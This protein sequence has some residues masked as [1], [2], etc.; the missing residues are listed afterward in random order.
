[1]K[2]ALFAALSLAVV[3]TASSAA[4]D[5]ATG[6]LSVTATVNKACTVG[7]GTLAF[8]TVVPA[9]G[10]TSPVTGSVSVTC[11]VGTTFDVGLGDGTNYSNPNRRMRV[12]AT[13]NYLTYEIYRD[14]SAT[15]RFGNTDATDRLTAQ[16][17][18]GSSANT[19]NVYGLVPSGQAGTAGEGSYTDTVVV[20]VIY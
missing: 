7:G 2:R 5:T 14:A 10:V 13:S 3:A 12:G 16:T 6:N 11:T 19:I 8:G 18:L 15:E 20:T 1:M 4:A 17:G 9:T